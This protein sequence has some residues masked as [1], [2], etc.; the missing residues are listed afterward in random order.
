MVRNSHIDIARA[1]SALN[2]I[3]S[4]C[5]RE[6]WVRVMTAAALSADIGRYVVEANCV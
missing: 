1:Q 5:D 4:D 3:S 6:T 2:A